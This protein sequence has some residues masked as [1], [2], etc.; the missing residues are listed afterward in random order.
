MKRIPVMVT[1][2]LFAAMAL[3]QQSPSGQSMP[4]QMP[5]GQAA[6]GDEQQLLSLEHQWCDAVKSGDAAALGRIE[7]DG[8]LFTTYTGKIISKQDDLNALKSGENKIQSCDV[9]DLEP[10]VYGDTAVVTGKV[11]IKGT[12]KGQDASGDYAFTDTFVRRE[13]RW[14]AVSTQETKLGGGS[15]TPSSQQPPPQ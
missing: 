3:A 9:S 11:S 14:Q 6:G 5:S 10:H 12:E 4:S 13:G 7:A 1:L 8:Y 15:M 2:M